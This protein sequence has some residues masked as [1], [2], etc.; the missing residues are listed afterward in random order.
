ML[1]LRVCVCSRASASVCVWWNVVVVCMLGECLVRAWFVR[2]DNGTQDDI[3]AFMKTCPIGFDKVIAQLTQMQK[4]VPCRSVTLGVG[5]GCACGLRTHIIAVVFSKYRVLESNILPKM[6]ALKQKMPELERTLQ[7][8][9]FLRKKQEADESFKTHF[10]LQ[11]NVYA[12]AE[13]EPSNS[14]F[15]WLGVRW[16]G[17]GAECRAAAHTHAFP[18]QANTMLEYT[19]DEATSLLTKNLADSKVEWVRR[20]PTC[21]AEP[22][23]A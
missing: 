15:L 21:S 22:S 12:K 16:H 4:Y 13:V 18:H 17:H 19:Y 8:I 10:N 3:D 9:E 7:M 11:D 6:S 5:V 14:V 23:S 1:T 2:M 20:W